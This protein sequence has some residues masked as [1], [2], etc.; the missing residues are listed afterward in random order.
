MRRLA[1]AAMIAALASGA[2]AQERS[3]A[4][5]QIISDLAYVLGESHALR[6][7]CEGASDQYWRDRMSQMLQAETPDEAFD[8]VLRENFN[9]GFSAA[10]AQFPTCDE[11][12]RAQAASIARRGA[13]LAQAAGKP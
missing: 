7:A 13:A 6:Q 3:P 8:R 4:Q 2:A 12:S 11:R 9:T 10:Q 5:H 1:I